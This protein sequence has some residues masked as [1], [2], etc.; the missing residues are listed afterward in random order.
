MTPSKGDTFEQETLSKKL[1]LIGKLK[2][3]LICDFIYEYFENVRYKL[4]IC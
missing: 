4:F 2:Q 1:Y 3:S